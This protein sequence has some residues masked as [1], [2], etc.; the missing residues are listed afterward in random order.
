MLRQNGSDVY[1]VIPVLE[2]IVY[3]RTYG[4]I[5]AS[6]NVGWLADHTVCGLTPLCWH[7]ASPLT[8]CK[9]LLLNHGWYNFG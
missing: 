2:A 7:L 3:T 4:F 6:L 9:V 1:Q 5:A 8:S